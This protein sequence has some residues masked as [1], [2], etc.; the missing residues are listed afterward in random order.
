MPRIFYCD[1][2]RFEHLYEECVLALPEE[3]RKKTEKL[4]NKKDRLLSAMAGLM[5]VKLFGIFAFEKMQYNEHGKPY[6]EHGPFFSISHSG[7]YAVL[8]VSDNEI[9]IDVE[10]RENPNFAVA[11]RCFTKEEQDFAKQSTRDFLRIW[12][13][14]EAVLKLL[15]TGFSYSPKKFC[16]LPFDSEHEIC[17]IKMRFFCGEINRT[18]IT[19]A[20]CGNDD[21][22]EVKEFLP[23]DLLN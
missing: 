8:A 17:G 19:C 1:A 4:I 13:A 20:F 10:D 16:V 22:F 5:A 23:K 7:R 15:G 3:R 12:T 21:I 9:G 11:K 2:D 14:K 6:F 18:P